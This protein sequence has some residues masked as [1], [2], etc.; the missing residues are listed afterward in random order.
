MATIQFYKRKYKTA[1]VINRQHS[2]SLHEEVGGEDEVLEQE[3]LPVGGAPPLTEEM[4]EELW[5][6]FW[7]WSAK[8]KMIERGRAGRHAV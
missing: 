8:Q 4:M 5:A 2:Y 1:V 7:T 3:W 6:K